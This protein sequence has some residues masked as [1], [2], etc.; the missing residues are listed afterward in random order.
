MKS[1]LSFTYLV[2]KYYSTI[3][4]TIF[5]LFL[6]LE[7]LVVVLLRVL[8]DYLLKRLINSYIEDLDIASIAT[9]DKERNSIKASELI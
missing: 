4:N 2:G 8:S 9:R 7:V 3:S 6:L 5:S 1:L